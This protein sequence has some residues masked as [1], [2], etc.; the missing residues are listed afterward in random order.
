MRSTGIPRAGSTPPPAPSRSSPTRRASDNTASG[1]YA[2]FGNATG[3]YNTASGREALERNMSGNSNTALGAL[4]G[5]YSETGHHN[6]FLGA[7]V[8]GLP[9][10]TNTIRIGSV[11]NGAA[12]PPTGQNQ[13]F[14]AGIRGTSVSDGLPVVIDADG[15]LGTVDYDNDNVAVGRGTLASSAGGANTATGAWALGDNTTGIGNTATGYDALMAQHYGRQQHRRRPSCPAQPTTR[16][17]T[18]RRPARACAPEQHEGQLQHG[19]GRIG[20]SYVTTGH[21]NLFLGA[22]VEGTASDTNTIRIGSAYSAGTRRR[23]AVRT[24]PSSRGFG[25]RRCQAVYR[26]SSTRTETGDGQRQRRTTRALALQHSPPTRRASPTRPP[27]RERSLPTRRATPTQRAEAMHSVSTKRAAETRRA[28]SWRSTPTS[29]VMG[30][31]PA[32]PRRW[33]TPRAP[34]TR[35]SAR[36]LAC[37]RRR[38]TTTYSWAPRSTA[39]R[40]TRIPSGLGRPITWA[41][42]RRA[43][44]TGP[45]S[46]ALSKVR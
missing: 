34:S 8:L 20:R 2:L 3:F 17:S 41:R 39:L 43:A 37:S 26:W 14:I 12:T 5:Y 38:A 23:R 13:T 19:A 11:Y 29:G 46:R 9:L 40:P 7:Y 21:Y 33:K 32:G 35:R 4:A 24:R 27:A 1:V 25:G 18:T 16:A 10:D 44:S 36:R 31:R 28:A 30:T 22:K 6:L 45:S 42:R 15:K